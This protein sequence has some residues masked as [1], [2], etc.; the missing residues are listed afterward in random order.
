MTFRLLPLLATHV[1]PLLQLLLRLLIIK[2]DSVNQVLGLALFV[3]VRKKDGTL[4][5]CV[6]YRR[7]QAV[8]K[9]DVLPL[10]SIEDLLAQLQGKCVFSTFDA[11]REYWQ[12]PVSA[13]SKQK[14]ELI[15]HEGLFEFDVIPFGLCNAPATF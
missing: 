8:T 13:E 3:I 15:T 6:D 5:F 11:R 7:L 1:M 12:I 2:N 9:K 14:T 4:R 10:L